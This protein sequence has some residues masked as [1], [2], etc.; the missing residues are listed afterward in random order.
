MLEGAPMGIEPRTPNLPTTAAAASYAIEW[1]IEA[2]D[3][4][5]AAEFAI[6]ALALARV[7]GMLNPG[8]SQ[9]SDRISAAIARGPAPAWGRASLL[10]SLIAARAAVRAANGV[11]QDALQ[12]LQLLNELQNEADG[13]NRALLRLAL[14]GTESIADTPQEA[15]DTAF[16]FGLL[17]SGKRDDVARLLATIETATLF[18]MVK[19]HFAE[20]LAMLLDGAAMA[21]FRAYDLPLAMRLSRARL[22]VQRQRSLGVATG[23]DFVRSS[24]CPDGSFGDF[25]AALARMAARGDPDGELRLKLP[26]TLQALW[27]MAEIEDPSFRLACVVFAGTDA[28]SPHEGWHDADGRSDRGIQA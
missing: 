5:D 17:R 20:P 2:W 19:R 18:G 8:L 23:F 10:P 9:A 24:Q 28:P 14:H 6:D 4:R 1:L 13:A 3:T 26:I 12:Y 15:S 16:D 11:A 22:Y 7:C 25:E 21:A 27:T